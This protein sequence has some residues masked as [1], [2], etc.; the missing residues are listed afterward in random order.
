MDYIVKRR[1]RHIASKA[2]CLVRAS[3]VSAGLRR[4]PDLTAVRGRFRVRRSGCALPAM[5]AEK[6]HAAHGARVSEG[7]RGGGCGQ[8]RLAVHSRRLGRVALPRAAA[9]AAVHQE[10][11]WLIEGK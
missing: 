2:A 5:V 4:G 10:S 3:E 8:G 11:R 7:A 1:V 6:N 9:G